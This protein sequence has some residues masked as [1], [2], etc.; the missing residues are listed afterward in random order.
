MR[1]FHQNGHFSRVA[2]I[3][4][5]RVQALVIWEAKLYFFQRK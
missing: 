4:R 3:C 1:I 2:I 5:A